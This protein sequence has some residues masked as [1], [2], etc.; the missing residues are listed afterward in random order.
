VNS[1][2]FKDIAA[3]YFDHCRVYNA[4]MTL[5]NKGIYV[6]R[7]VSFFGDRDLAGIARADVERYVRSRKADDAGNPT[8]NHELATLKHLFNYAILSGYTECNPVKGIK[9]LPEARRP[10]ALPTT[11]EVERW[12]VWCLQNDL[13]LYDL[14]AIAVN[15]GLRKGDILKIRGENVDLER[16]VLA[17]AVSKTRG[18][19]YIPLNDVALRVLAR[20]KVPGYIFINGSN[21]LKSFKRRFRR[22]KTATGLPC[23]F[24]DFRHF[25]ATEIHDRGASVRTVQ[26]LLGHADIK[27][28]EIYLEATDAGRRRAV[29]LLRWSYVERR[30]E[31]TLFEM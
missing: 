1:V 29:E 6:R 8:I 26:T 13:L 22:A 12:L 10:L 2:A 23:R 5:Y 20:R 28:T 27:T 18:V 3:D 21:H 19:Q 9:L 30:E 4:A 24:H 17:V 11:A 14:S 31:Y 7:F 15:T 25:F 16:R